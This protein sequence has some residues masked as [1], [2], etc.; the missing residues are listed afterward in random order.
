MRSLV[1][2]IARHILSSPEKTVFYLNHLGHREALSNCEVLF[3]LWIIIDTLAAEDDIAYLF[4]QSNGIFNTFLLGFRTTL[5]A[6]NPRI[7]II[8]NI[9]RISLWCK[10]R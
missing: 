10:S 3:C 8:R 5:L 9:R 6:I 1:K 7:W 4:Y 2:I